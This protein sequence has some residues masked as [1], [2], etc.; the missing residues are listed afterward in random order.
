MEDH[1]KRLDPERLIAALRAKEPELKD[2]EELTGNIMEAIRKKAEIRTAPVPPVEK[3]N[4]QLTLL[5]RLLAAASV[6]LFMVFSYEQYVVV[7]KIGRL[8]IQNASISQD[9][10]YKTAIRTSQ[11][12]NL[13]KSDP[14]LLKHYKQMQEENPQKSKL[15]K[16]GL[17]FNLLTTTKIDSI[18]QNLQK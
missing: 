7:D 11:V 3:P 12:L 17:I 14:E 16:A 1:N 2:P 18:Y 8:E 9:K 15:I 13:L 4:R 10:K 6:C 5:L